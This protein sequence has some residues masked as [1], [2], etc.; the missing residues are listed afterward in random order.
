MA[1]MFALEHISIL[2]LLFSELQHKCSPITPNFAVFTVKSITTM[3]NAIMTKSFLQIGRILTL[4][5]TWYSFLHQHWLQECPCWDQVIHQ[6][7]LKCTWWHHFCITERRGRVCN[8]R[9]FETGRDPACIKNRTHLPTS[10]QFYDVRLHNT[11]LPMYATRCEHSTSSK[12]TGMLLALP[13]ETKMLSMV[14]NWRG[15]HSHSVKR[16][17]SLW[18]MCL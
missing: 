13:D 18:V 5:A 8:C 12:E 15:P 1:N 16:L 17:A 4:G 3:N 6:T 2:H 14:D 7:I 11:V 9:K 10:L